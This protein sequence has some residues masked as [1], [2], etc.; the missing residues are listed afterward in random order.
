ML[1][2]TYNNI[3]FQHKQQQGKI[4]LANNSSNYN[5]TSCS[6]ISLHFLLVSNKAIDF[7]FLIKYLQDFSK[8]NTDIWKR[9]LDDWKGRWKKNVSSRDEIHEENCWFHTLGPQKKLGNFKK[10]ESRANF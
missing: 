2:L 7:P 6:K 5:Y 9:E 8:T 10:F 3:Q 4:V 1:P